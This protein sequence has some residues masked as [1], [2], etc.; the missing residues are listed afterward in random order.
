MRDNET[1]LRSLT[2]EED[3][4]YAMRILRGPYGGPIR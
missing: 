4:P 2:L 3:S 1:S